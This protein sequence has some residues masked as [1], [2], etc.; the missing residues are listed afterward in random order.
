MLKVAEGFLVPNLSLGKP[1]V[2]AFFNAPIS[3]PGGFRKVRF[4]PISR[5]LISGLEERP[6]DP[7]IGFCD[8][9]GFLPVFELKMY[10]FP[11][12]NGGYS[13]ASYVR[14]YQRVPF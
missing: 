6:L 12:E 11:I 7:S 4:N 9:A 2:V 3:S 13:I 8:L 1:Q 5:V 14:T 10:I